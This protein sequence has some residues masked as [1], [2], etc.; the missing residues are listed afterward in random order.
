MHIRN[1]TSFR[2]LLSNKRGFLGAKYVIDETIFDTDHNI[3]LFVC[4]GFKAK[5]NKKFT[6]L[7][8][9]ESTSRLRFGCTKQKSISLPSWFI[10]TPTQSKYV[11][12]CVTPLSGQGFHSWTPH[13]RGW[14]GGAGN[15][16]GGGAISSFDSTQVQTCHRLS[17]LRVQQQALRSLRMLKIPDPALDKKRPNSRVADQ[18]SVND[19][20]CYS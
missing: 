2:G 15:G 14:G 7:W 16:G 8:S 6:I 5:K 9:T 17:R 10:A 13:R 18:S 4:S 19:D 1:A 11:S 12:K 20:C 3:G